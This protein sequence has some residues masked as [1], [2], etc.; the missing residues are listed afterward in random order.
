MNSGRETNRRTFL[1]ATT[2]GAS[3]LIAVPAVLR[4]ASP[5][6]DPVR[7]GH[8]GTGTRGWDLIKYMGATN[9]AKVVAVCDVYKPHLRSDVTERR[10]AE[11]LL[12]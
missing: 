3:T 11:C 6:A 4:G 10:R 7:V 12:E 8:I 9:S 5:T 1:K 2:L